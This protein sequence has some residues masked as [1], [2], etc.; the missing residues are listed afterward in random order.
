ME[1]LFKSIWEWFTPPDPPIT[2]FYPTL[3]IQ[4]VEGHMKAYRAWSLKVSGTLVVFSV[5]I[6][7]ACFTP[8]GFVKAGDLDAK[9]SA[10]VQQ[11]VAAIIKDQQAAKAQNDQIA[12]SI[13]E[14]L[15]AQTANTIC[16]ILN[17]KV[18]D[19]AER[20][21]RRADADNEQEKYKAV[22]GEYYPESRCGSGS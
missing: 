12:R 1:G 9:L 13:N 16:R 2:D 6:I 10:A 19:V 5:G 15:R 7:I 4:K 8:W 3:D 17:N 14:I 18:T 11:T 20:A 21:Q 22:T